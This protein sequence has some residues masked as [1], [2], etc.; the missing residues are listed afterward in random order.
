MPVAKEEGVDHLQFSRPL[1]STSLRTQAISPLA[2]A[3]NISPNGDGCLLDTHPASTSAAIAANVSFITALP[4]R[5]YNDYETTSAA[6]AYA[7]PC[8]REWSVLSSHTG[9]HNRPEARS[10]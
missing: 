2:L 4:I 10:G 8:D 1:T 7:P 3:A 9:A 6:G 5:Q